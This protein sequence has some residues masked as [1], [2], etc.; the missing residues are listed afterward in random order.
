MTWTQTD[1]ALPDDAMPDMPVPA[2]CPSGGAVPSPYSI[3][4]STPRISSK[5][6]GGKPLEN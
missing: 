6:N 3:T 2:R 5:D 1:V 4:R